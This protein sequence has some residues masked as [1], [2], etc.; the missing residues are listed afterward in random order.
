MVRTYT[1]RELAQ[2]WNVS[3]STVKR[4]ADSGDLVCERTPGGHRRFS[5]RHVHE[6]QK[7]RGFEATGL[8]SSPEW[9]DPDLEESLNQKDF[10]KVR[11]QVVY[12]AKANQRLGIEELLE[13]LYL[14]GIAVCDIYDD[15]LVPAYRAARETIGRGGITDGQARLI[16]NNLEEAMY[17]LFPRM[18]RRRPNGKM[19]L[20]ANPASGKALTLNAAARVLETEG[21]E[22]LNLGSHVSYGSMAEMVEIEPINLVCV[23][24]ADNGEIPATASD[25]ARLGKVTHAY[26]IPVVL[27]GESFADPTYRLTVPESHVFR[28]LRSLRGFV[29]GLTR[30]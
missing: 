17:G 5:L 20:C 2:I 28:N 15:I 6:F 10:D 4:W 16:Y 3:E 23:V 9:E 1:T 30:G 12:L 7:S 25:L 24:A 27:L 18:S 19:S 8:L 14:R 11:E 13:R 21:W 26:R 29:A 22:T